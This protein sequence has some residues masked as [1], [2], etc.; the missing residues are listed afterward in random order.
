MADSLKSLDEF[1]SGESMVRQDVFGIFLCVPIISPVV[2]VEELII[3][4]NAQN[5]SIYHQ[6]FLHAF[7]S[8]D[9]TSPGLR[10]VLR[11][12]QELLQ[13]AIDVVDSGLFQ[14]LSIPTA[15][16]LMLDAVTGTMT[17]TS[18]ILAAA[19]ANATSCLQE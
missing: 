5:Q 12:R 11:T 3:S 9:Q 7:H 6:E 1:D 4:T 10:T 17:P 13:I 16:S 14:N 8:E 15:A 19:D 2:E 18:A